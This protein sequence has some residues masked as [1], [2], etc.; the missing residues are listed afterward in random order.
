MPD[1]FWAR[2]AILFF[3]RPIGTLFVPVAYEAVVYAAT[4][5]SAFEV[6][7]LLAVLNFALYIRQ[8]WTERHFLAPCCQ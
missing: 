4:P 1:G 5:V 3:V 8:V 7:V 6:E 2:V